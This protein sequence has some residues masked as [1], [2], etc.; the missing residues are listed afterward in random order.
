MSFSSKLQRIDRR[1]IRMVGD[2]AL[3]D[4]KPIKGFL[5][6]P[7]GKPSIG[8]LQT[9]LEEP[10]FVGMF[11]DLGIAAEGSTLSVE[12]ATGEESFVVINK[13]PYQENRSMLMLVLRPE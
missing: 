11:E 7:W 10:V 2:D 5:I 1:L 8:G 6:T 3:L 12:L 13:G 9:N 4:D